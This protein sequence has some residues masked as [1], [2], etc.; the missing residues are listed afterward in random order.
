MRRIPFHK[1]NVRNKI[2]MKFYSQVFGNIVKLSENPND[3]EI[4]IPIYE[5]NISIFYKK[6]EPVSELINR[7]KGS[8]EKVERVEII[9]PQPEK[10]E[11]KIKEQETIQDLIKTP[12]E[13]KINN[14]QNI[15]FFPSI[16]GVIEEATKTY[17]DR[18]LGQPSILNNYNY[19]LFKTL[20]SK[21]DR[22]TIKNE[23]D[24]GLNSLISKYNDLLKEYIKAEEVIEQRMEKKTRLYINLGLLFFI[25][26]A[27]LFYFLI[28]Q[29]Y[30]WDTI[31]PVTYIVGNVYWIIGLGFFVFKKKKLDFSFFSS[32]A[33]RQNFFK[34]QG[35]LLGFNQIEKEFLMKEIRDMKKFQ[36]ALNKV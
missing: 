23:V 12:F 24:K 15:K 26:H 33:F 7:I 21:A 6:N 20:G 32:N 2:N 10:K 14:Y 11:E 4:K 31:E 28:Y 17:I 22:L 9:R 3:N 1:L 8:H 30:G 13:I 19:F 5:Q 29:W 35:K 18:T 16:N 34:S 27:I 25:A 36:E